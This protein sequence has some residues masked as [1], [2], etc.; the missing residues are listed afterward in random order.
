[1]P[2]TPFHFGPGLFIKSLARKFSFTVFIFSQFVIDLE[3]LYFI[4]T[5]N[6]PVHRLLH[7]FL[8]SNIVMLISIL[9]GKPICESGLKIFGKVF[10]FKE[11]INISWLAAI[12]TSMLGAYSHVFFDSLMHRDIKPFWPFTDMN[13]LLNQVSISSLHGFCLTAFAAGGIF[14]LFQRGYK[15]LLNS[16]GK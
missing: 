8:G 7:T 1:M 9:L 11:E 2:F 6:P 13:P 10:C 14:Y 16:Q 5:N 4:L 12:W 3:P 15:L